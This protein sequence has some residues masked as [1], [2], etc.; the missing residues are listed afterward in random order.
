[1][2]VY[3]ITECTKISTHGEINKHFKII[4]THYQSIKYIINSNQETA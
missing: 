3:L 2:F 1:M 4:L